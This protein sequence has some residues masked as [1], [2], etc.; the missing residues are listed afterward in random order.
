LT[1]GESDIGFKWSRGQR[2]LL[3]GCGERK[4]AFAKQCFLFSC[5]LDL[6]EQL[7]DESQAKRDAA[8]ACCVVILE[9]G[10]PAAR[11]GRKAREL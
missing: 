10:K 1:P 3:G 9:K 4:Q 7:K 6:I 11:S 5:G 2:K 8:R